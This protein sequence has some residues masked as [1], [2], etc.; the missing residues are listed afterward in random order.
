MYCLNLLNFILTVQLALQSDCGIVLK[1]SDECQNV[2]KVCFEKGVWTL[3]V[4]LLETL[5]LSGM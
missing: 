5:F 3:Y 4:P 2:M 1:I